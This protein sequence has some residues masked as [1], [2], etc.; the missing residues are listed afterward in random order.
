MS[1]H[2]SAMRLLSAIAVTL[3]A[4]GQGGAAEPIPLPKPR[5]ATI[6]ERFASTPKA[7]GETSPITSL[8]PAPELH[9]L[10]FGDSSPGLSACDLRLA[11]LAE[12]APMP[13]LVG[14]GE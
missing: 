5:P 2:E 3:I 14:P 7:S 12:F 10:P 4:A 9:N 8:A 13:A 6:A 11:E 1:P